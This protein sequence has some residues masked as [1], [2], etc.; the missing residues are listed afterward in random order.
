[1]RSRTTKRGHVV[2]GHPRE[3]KINL[4]WWWWWWYNLIVCVRGGV[5][6]C[7][8]VGEHVSKRTFYTA[9]SLTPRKTAK[10][11]GIMRIY[12]LYCIALAPCQ[13]DL[14]DYRPDVW[15]A[16]RGGV[17]LPRLSHCHACW[18]SV[19]PC[20][21]AP[22]QEG[23]HEVLPLTSSFQHGRY[24]PDPGLT[25]RGFQCVKLGIWIVPPTA[26][27][28]YST[29]ASCVTDVFGLYDLRV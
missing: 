6:S 21:K 8:K 15:S 13:S 11:A 4:F 27:V 12:W 22:R 3:N 20:S 18:S 2:A 28:S 9:E 7:E 14:P 24:T 25:C 26:W 23:G 5:T 16:F 29:T 19:L 1:M 17:P 10:R